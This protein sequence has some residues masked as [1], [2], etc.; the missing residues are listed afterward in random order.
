M[1]N[2]IKI[3]R[4]YI[5]TFS[6]DNQLQIPKAALARK[7]HHDYPHIF[8]NVEN[9]RTIIRSA[10]GSQGNRR[11]KFIKEKDIQMGTETFEKLYSLPK[12][13]YNDYTP[14]ICTGKRVL[15]ISDIHIPYHSLEAL[16]SAINYGQENEMD[17]ILINGDLI[18]FYHISRFEKDPRKRSLA[19]EIEMTRNFLHALANNHPNV[20]IIFKLGNHE[21]RWE[22]YLKAHAPVLLDMAEFRLDV[23]LRLAEKGI[24]YIA[25]KKIIKIGH[26]NVLHGHEFGRQI[27][28]PVNPARGAWMRSK[29]NILVGH[30]HNTSEHVEKTLC[31]KV[32]GAW[33]VG[34]LSELN[35]EYMPINKYNHGFAFVVNKGETFEVHNEKIITHE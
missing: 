31:G 7:L 16:E 1:S 34:C 21:E 27:F 17:T 5:D 3:V 23:I 35:P 33:S 32:Q 15:I 2:K 20:K 28:S 4:E 10:T 11:R 6:K 8:D 18:D 19:E 22:H 13:D 25:E 12:G 14:Y 24:E 26:L 30:H 29:E 9:A